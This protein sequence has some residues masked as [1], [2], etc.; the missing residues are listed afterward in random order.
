M[1]GTLTGREMLNA[2]MR[3]EAWSARDTPFLTNCRNRR[4]SP[5]GARLFHSLT[6]PISDAAI[7]GLGETKSWPY[8]IYFRGRSVTLLAF[9]TTIYEWDGAAW[10]LIDT[11]DA[12]DATGATSK[13]LTAGSDWHFLDMGPT[14]ML[15][16]ISTVVWKTGR[17]TNVWAADDINIFSGIAHKHARALMGGFFPASFYARVD[18]PTYWA[19]LRTN[20]LPADYSS[21]PATGMDKNWVRWSAYLAPDLLDLLDATHLQTGDVAKDLKWRNDAG[22]MAL[23]W[24]GSMLGFAELG[25]G[26]VCYGT[27]GIT[28]LDHIAS[29]KRYAPREFAG[30]G[31]RLG[32]YV[33]PSGLP[34]SRTHWTGSKNVQYFVDGGDELWRLTPDLQAEHLGHKEWIGELTH[35][36]MLLSYDAMHDELYI[37]DGT[38]AL[39]LSGGRMCRPPWQPTRISMAGRHSIDAVY[40]DSA[41]TTNVVIETGTMTTKSGQLETLSRIWKKGYDKS[42]GGW[43]VTVRYRVRTYDD[44]TDTDAFAFDELGVVEFGI[45]VLEYRLKFTTTDADITLD[46]FGWELTTEPPQMASKLAADAAGAATE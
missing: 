34:V 13:S 38:D 3:P 1:P 12:D 39:M 29:L 14:W 11:K 44:F 7:T 23:P 6:A 26:V 25:D 18:W 4:P 15:F 9:E 37:G 45:G 28:Y 2:G 46:D 5:D 19:G 43:S 33:N 40:F 8:P 36:S 31:E 30:L 22:G 16:N 24:Q 20:T 17:S 21:L 10:N 32:V 42:S 35:D 27:G 41:D